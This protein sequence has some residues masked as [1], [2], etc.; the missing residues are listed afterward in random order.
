MLDAGKLEPSVGR[1]T[2]IA[3]AGALGVSGATALAGGGLAPAMPGAGHA[4]GAAGA[5]AGIV[6]ARDMVRVTVEVDRTAL[7]GGLLGY[8]QSPGN[9]RESGP[10][11]AAVDS[12]KRLGLPVQ[13]LEAMLIEGDVTREDVE[14]L[15]DGILS[16]HEHVVV[17]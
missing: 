10:M 4:L 11:V 12:A 14:A 2:V 5:A 7:V 16:G 1:R 6:A 9:L 15:V 8:F 3:G 13:L 17:Y